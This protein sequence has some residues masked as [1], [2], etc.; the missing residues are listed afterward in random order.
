MKQTTDDDINRWKNSQL[1][2]FTPMDQ[3]II[4]PI[5][6]GDSLEWHSFTKPSVMDANKSGVDLIRLYLRI[7]KASVSSWSATVY[8]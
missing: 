7:T 3:F 1:L 5:L 6:T 8:C 2:I 4:D